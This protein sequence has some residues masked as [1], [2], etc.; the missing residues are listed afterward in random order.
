[1]SN[2]GDVDFS[3]L[4]KFQK[5][6]EKLAK[7][8]EIQKLNEKLIKE[9]AAR[10]LS[11]VI[12]LTPVCNSY[13]AGSGK[14]GGT[15]R[16]GWTSKTEA[17]AEIKRTTNVNSYLDSIDVEKVGGN[18]QITI[19]N[20]VSYASYVEYGHRTRALHENKK[21]WTDGYFML[22]ISEQELNSQKDAIIEK[23]LNEYIKKCF[24]V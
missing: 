13:P 17:D 22:T 7:E 8:D 4:E 21:L 18:Y 19:L 11:K 14:V 23:R 10:L 20:P 9:L 12:D 1:M 24:N 6:L 2:F 15:L 3:Q 16:R 5:Q